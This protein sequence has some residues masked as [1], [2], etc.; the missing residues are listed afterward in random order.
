MLK[1]KKF[2]GEKPPDPHLQG[3]HFAA[4][5]GEGREGTEERKEGGNM[6][7]WL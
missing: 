1:S 6:R 5:G 7:H 4:G 3:S 2:P